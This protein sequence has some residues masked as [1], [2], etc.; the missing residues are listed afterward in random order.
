MPKFDVT[1]AD[2]NKAKKV[3]GKGA[4]SL[5]IT[6]PIKEY[7]K[8]KEGLVKSKTRENYNTATAALKE[9]DEARKK[10]EAKLGKLDKFPELFT[11]M[12]GKSEGSML[13]AIER[14]KS[15]LKGVEQEIGLAS[16][17]EKA[18]SKLEAGYEM[19]WQ[20][21]EQLRT[22]LEDKRDRK[23]FAIAM[24]ALRKLSAQAEKIINS[25]ESE[26]TVLKF[27]YQKQVKVLASLDATM[28]KSAK[29][30]E[31]ALASMVREREELEQYFQQ[32]NRLLSQATKQLQE[33]KIQAQTA[34][35]KELAE[36]LLTHK[37]SVKEVTTGAINK[38]NEV[39]N[40]KYKSGSKLRGALDVAASK[41]S[42]D[43]Q[44]QLILPHSTKNFKSFSELTKLYEGI[45][46][47][48]KEILLMK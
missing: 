43:D 45:Q 28:K 18:G 36:E 3:H 1:I 17:I 37:K 13:Y 19:L 2:W 11:I 39:F 40:E 9:L 30:Y 35:E 46:S 23:T 21:F 48:A 5:G 47:L 29:E 20:E 16:K 32:V 15:W 14:E 10:A 31:D 42:L 7:E 22:S 12:G 44:K 33:L 34:K 6:P 25:N 41:A 8:A 4:P 38:Y 27:K 24:E 26:D